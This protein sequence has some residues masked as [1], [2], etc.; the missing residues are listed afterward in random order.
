MRIA[1]RSR[2]SLY[3]GNPHVETADLTTSEIIQSRTMA[4]RLEEEKIPAPEALRYA[5][6]LADEIRKIHDS[7]S[8]HG[9]ITPENVELT[10][11]GLELYASPEPGGITPYTAPEIIEG[12]PQSAAS[13]V[14]SFGAVVYEML[15]GRRAYEGSNEQELAGRILMSQPVALGSPAVDRLIG[16]CL[17]K[18]PAV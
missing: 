5:I 15:A 14:F 16:C 2:Q 1:A 6:A 18:D 12:H 10:D 7:G 3:Q 11:S 8:V 4:E 17:A 13:D 9:A